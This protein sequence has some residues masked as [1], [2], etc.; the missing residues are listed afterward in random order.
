MANNANIQTTT[1]TQSANEILGTKE[2]TLYYLI[3]ETPKGKMTINV[4]EKTHNAVQELTNV[5]TKIE[6]I[7]GKPDETKG[8]RK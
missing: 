4:G 6:G 1:V 3:V 5:V 7:G 8:G 2:R